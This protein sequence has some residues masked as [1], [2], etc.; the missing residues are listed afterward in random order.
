[1]AA[2]SLYEG[3]WHRTSGASS[4]IGVGVSSGVKRESG[5]MGIAAAASRIA[6]SVFFVSHLP[7]G[8]ASLIMAARAQTL[9]RQPSSRHLCSAYGY[10]ILHQHAALAACHQY[11]CAVISG[12]HSASPRARASAASPSLFASLFCLTRNLYRDRCLVRRSAKRGDAAGAAKENGAAAWA[13]VVNGMTA[14]PITRSRKPTGKANLG[15]QAVYSFFA[16]A[17]WVNSHR[18]DRG[19]IFCSSREKLRHASTLIAAALAAL[20][21]RL[22]RARSSSACRHFAHHGVHGVTL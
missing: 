17:C 1:M 18:M 8:A 5:E 13:R 14:A 19:G 20:A 11:A 2:I 9:R 7:C 15:K 12:A 22:A 4:T 3:I 21:P 10:G 16:H 6:A